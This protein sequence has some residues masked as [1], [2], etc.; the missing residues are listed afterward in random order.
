[1]KT[2]KLIEAT[3]KVALGDAFHQ[4]LQD[5]FLQD[6]ASGKY[7]GSEQEYTDAMNILPEMFSE[8]KLSILKQY[9]EIA[10]RVREFHGSYGFLTGLYCGFQQWF[11]SDQESDGGFTRY[12]VNDISQIPRMQRHKENFQNLELLNQLGEQ[13]SEGE[14]LSTNEHIISLQC[15]WEQRS[16]SAAVD[17][18]YVGYRAALD[19]IDYIS[20]ESNCK[21]KMMGK[22]L[23]V[24]CMLGYIDSYEH[25]ERLMK[26]G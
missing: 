16:H 24:E 9:V 17:G 26:V 15:G 23:S 4:A 8:E 18:F 19:L 20:P 5:K 6:V 11:T 3:A 21:N 25:Q 14:E 1:M 12:V 2:A 7:A 10:S 22:L 13:L